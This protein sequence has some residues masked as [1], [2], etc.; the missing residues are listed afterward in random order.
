MAEE[1]DDLG[2]HA[3]AFGIPLP[4]TMV[5]AMME[6][7]DTARAQSED[8]Y[9]ATMR[10]LDSLDVEGLMSLRWV[11]ACD[12]E[13]A[14]GNARFYDGMAAQLLRAK[15]V[16]PS[17]G[18]DPAAQLLATAAAAAGDAPSAG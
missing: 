5:R 4:A 12:A 11:L 2:H 16:D 3:H 9:N 8:R 6:G 7:R 15:G 10:W 14:F 1:D 18:L 17:T 13:G